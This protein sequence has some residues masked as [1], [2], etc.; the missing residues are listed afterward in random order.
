MDHW[1]DQMEFR[2][3]S[4]NIARELWVAGLLSYVA[5]EVWTEMQKHLVD[6]D[7]TKTPYE[8]FVLKM[9]EI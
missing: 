9:K 7:P 2:L 6:K 8:E 1:I 3:K 5:P 4:L